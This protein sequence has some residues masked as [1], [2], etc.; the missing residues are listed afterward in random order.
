MNE[1]DFEKVRVWLGIVIYGMGVL[2]GW[3]LVFWMCW[4]AA[5]IGWVINL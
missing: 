2:A 1:V 4:L 5:V 3:L